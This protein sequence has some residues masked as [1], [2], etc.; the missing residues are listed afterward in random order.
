VVEIFQIPDDENLRDFIYKK[1]DHWIPQEGK[2]EHYHDKKRWD[3]LPPNIQKRLERGEWGGG[4]WN[5]FFE[6]GE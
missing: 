1:A 5:E 4:P 6:F 3:H 2:Y